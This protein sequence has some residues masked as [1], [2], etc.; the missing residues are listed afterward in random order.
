MATRARIRGALAPLLKGGRALEGRG[1]AFGGQ[2]ERGLQQLLRKLYGSEH[3][4]KVVVPLKE[5]T[6]AV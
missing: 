1:I 5:K 4:A 6:L 3:M 2:A